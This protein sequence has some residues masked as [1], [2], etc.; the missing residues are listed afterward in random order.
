MRGA[1]RSE[2][3]NQKRRLCQRCLVEWLRK[4]KEN[5]TCFKRS[6]ATLLQLRQT[7]FAQGSFLAAAQ[8]TTVAINAKIHATSSNSTLSRDV[9]GVAPFLLQVHFK[10]H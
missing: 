2:A 3:N 1:N 6:S 7:L 4:R 8:E 9:P 10:A 5:S